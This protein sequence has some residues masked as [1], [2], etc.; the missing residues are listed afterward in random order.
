MGYFVS[1]LRER[2]ANF[3]APARRPAT[4]RGA[5]R[6]RPTLVSGISIND[7]RKNLRDLNEHMDRECRVVG[8]ALRHHA[9]RLADHRHRPA[10]RGRVGAGG[11]QH[12]AQPG[13]VATSAWRRPRPIRRSSSRKRAV[14]I[15]TLKAQA[16]VEPLHARWPSSWPTLK[17]S[18]PDALAAYLRNV[19]LGLFSKAH[20]GHPGGEAM[21]TLLPAPSSPSSLLFIVVPIVAR[22]RARCSASTPSSR[23]A[24]CHVY[25][26]FGKVLGDARRAGP[27]LPAGSSSGRRRFIVNW[28]GKLPRA[29]H[30]ARPGVPA[31]P[32]GQLRGR[33][34]DGHRHLVRD[35]HQ[36]PGRVPVQEHRPARLAARPTSATPRCAA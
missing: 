35:V 30:A 36:R 22:P 8:G 19:R 27:A 15:E 20:A 25:V 32:A 4:P 3:E 6:P 16:E 9:R 26:L 29:R 24:R 21:M 34:A 17:R 13:L 5:S 12:R 33:R 23:S 7:L 28:L 2:I 18:G 10:A 14:E 11:D 1:V 31:Q